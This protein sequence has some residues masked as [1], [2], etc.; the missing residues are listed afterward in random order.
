ML[1]N[2]AHPHMPQKLSDF[3]AHVMREKDLSTYAVERRSHGAISQSQVARIRLGDV[4]QPSAD[5]LK[6]L[7]KGL[8]VTESEL[9]SVVRGVANEPAEITDERLHSIQDAYTELPKKKQAKADLLIEMIARE[10]VRLKNE[11]E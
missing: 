3:V 2:D 11:P 1:I 5:K 10:I 6:A 7:A 9:F 4:R 8:G